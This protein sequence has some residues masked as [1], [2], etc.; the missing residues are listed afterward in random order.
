MMVKGYPGTDRVLRKYRDD[1]GD[2]I[3]ALNGMYKKGLQKYKGENKGNAGAGDG[4]Q[5][6][7]M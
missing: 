1:D 2:C 4:G 6:S 5:K 3:G 7:G